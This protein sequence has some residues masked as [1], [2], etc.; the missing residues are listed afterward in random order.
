MASRWNGELRTL[1]SPGPNADLPDSLPIQNYHSIDAPIHLILHHI[2]LRWIH[3]YPTP[4]FTPSHDLRLRPF[5]TH[6]LHTTVPLPRSYTCSDLFTNPGSLYHVVAYSPFRV[7]ISFFPVSCF[8][9]HLTLSTLDL[10]FTLYL[11]PP[12]TLNY[13]TYGPVP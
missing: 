10:I 7:S 11:H 6:T 9:I 5:A 13:L 12:P 4:H 2:R 1:P 3:V 8:V